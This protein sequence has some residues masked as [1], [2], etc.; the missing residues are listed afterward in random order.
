M[1]PQIARHFQQLFSGS[2]LLVEAPGRINL[3]G[4]HTDYNNGWVMPAAIDKHIYFAMGKNDSPSTFEFHSLQFSEHAQFET[5][6]DIERVQPWVRYLLAA[7]QELQKRGYTVKGTSGVLGGDIPVGA[8]LSS[9][10]ALCCGF[11]FG[12]SNLYALDLSREEIALI[13]QATEHRIGINCGLMDQYA[14]LFGKADHVTLLDCE[15]LVP[16]NI[17][18]ALGDYELYIIN[19]KIK[20]ELAADSGYNERRAS[21]ERVVKAA[22]QLDPNINSLRGVSIDTLEQLS[23]AISMKDFRRA[24][25]VLH[26]NQRVLEASKALRISNMDK[27]G[28][29][30]YA[31]HEGMRLEYQITVPQIDLLVNLAKA[32]A[33]EVLGARMMGGGFGGCTINIIRKQV[34]RRTLGKITAAYQMETGLEAE[35]HKVKTGD[36]VRVVDL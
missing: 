18:L 2:M 32:N 22:K 1:L 6:D 26:E 33:D 24:R 4:E 16:E 9:S 36:G 25:Y 23:D 19:S 14:S 31:A 7:V 15:S 34:A 30:L 13:A 28:S 17:P 10:A 11:I 5:N 35:V 29:L 27:L 21:C 12:L 20:H 8:G 3:I